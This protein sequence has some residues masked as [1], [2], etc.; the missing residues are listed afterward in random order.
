MSCQLLRK[1]ECVKSLVE[2]IDGFYFRPNRDSDKFCYENAPL[3]INLLNKILPDELCQKAGLKRKTS[4]N[5]RVSCASI[6]FQNTVEEKLIRERTGHSRYPA[7]IVPL[8]SIFSGALTH[9]F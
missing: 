7:G 8:V 3:G 5:L 9:R 4:H 1:I 6:L 2:K